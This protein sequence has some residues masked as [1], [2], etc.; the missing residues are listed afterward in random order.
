MTSLHT[1]P[2]QLAWTFTHVLPGTFKR[3]K[4][5]F[6]HHDYP[7]LAPLPSKQARTTALEGHDEV[8]PFIYFVVDAAEQICY[9]GKT[10][11][12]TV[13]KRWVRPGLGGPATHYWTHSTSSG[14]TVFNI[15]EGLR[16]GQGPY[17]LRF[18]ALSKLLDSHGARFG[19]SPGMND[20]DALAVIEAGLIRDLRPQWNR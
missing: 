3:N 7:I 20:T 8:G 13:V 15:A 16:R 6:A 17:S 1:I 19:V 9:V 12:A 11:E 5:Q 18:V 14:G 4:A 2:T 10:Q